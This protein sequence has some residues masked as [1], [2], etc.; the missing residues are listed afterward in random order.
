MSK[1]ERDDKVSVGR[2]I[3]RMMMKG[4]MRREGVACLPSVIEKKDCL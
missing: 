1:G 2:L 4:C 3:K